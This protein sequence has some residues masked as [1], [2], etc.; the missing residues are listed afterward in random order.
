MNKN[1]DCQEIL[2]FNEEYLTY[3]YRIWTVHVDIRDENSPTFLFS[4]PIQKEDLGDKKIVK[5]EVLI[6]FGIRTHIKASEIEYDEQAKEIKRNPLTIYFTTLQNMVEHCE[7][8][9][10]DFHKNKN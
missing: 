6:Y 9:L 8:F 10:K 7:K 5:S 2:G 1:N 3:Y 4:L